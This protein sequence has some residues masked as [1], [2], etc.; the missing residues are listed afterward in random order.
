M[1]QVPAKQIYLLLVIIV[2]I[3]ALS[4][5]STYA[6][7]TFENTTGDIVSIHIPKSLTISENVYEYQQ[8]KIA[9]N[10]VA[11]TDIDISHSKSSVKILYSLFS[12]DS[13]PNVIKAIPINRIQ[14]ITGDY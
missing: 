11:T 7:F 12:A 3:I 1:K 4:V 5:Y 10:Q 8:I 2:G 9:P 14:N 6:L 13:I